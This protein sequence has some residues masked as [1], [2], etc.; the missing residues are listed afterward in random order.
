MSPA[1]RLTSKN[2]SKNWWSKESD[3]KGHGF[4]R[5][6]GLAEEDAALAAEGCFSD[7]I[8]NSAFFRSL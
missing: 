6:V 3:L 4:S 7:I 2:L 8:Q 1:G 5:A